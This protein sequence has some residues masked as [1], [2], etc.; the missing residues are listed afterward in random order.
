MPNKTPDI[1]DGTRPTL[2]LDVEKYQH[3]LDMPDVDDVQRK[4]LIEAL[5][6]LVV[7]FMDAGFD[8]RT[9]EN[10]GEA[11]LPANSCSKI[12]NDKVSSNQSPNSAVFAAAANEPATKQEAS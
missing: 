10:C 4:E 7:S 5:W 6:L 8:V 9:A 3:M 11:P 1:P 12:G 2:K